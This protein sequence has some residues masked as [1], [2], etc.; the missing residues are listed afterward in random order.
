[1]RLSMGPRLVWRA[2]DADGCRGAVHAATG[3]QPDGF[4]PHCQGAHGKHRAVGIMAADVDVP[5]A[6]AGHHVPRTGPMA[7]PLPWFL[8]YF[9]FA[10]GMAPWAFPCIA[11]PLEETI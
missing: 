9:Q 5:G 6:G 10:C 2:P 1:F 8:N 11:T 3:R 4:L 7:A